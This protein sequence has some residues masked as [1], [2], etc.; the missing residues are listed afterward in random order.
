MRPPTTPSFQGKKLLSPLPSLRI[1]HHQINKRW[2]DWSGMVNSCAGSLIFGYKTSNDMC[3]IIST[4]RRS[5]F[6]MENW[7]HF[8]VVW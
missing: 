3:L 4:L 1:H 2:T 6:F 8:M 5:K 7:Y